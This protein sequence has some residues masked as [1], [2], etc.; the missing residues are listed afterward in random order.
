MSTDK[1]KPALGYEIETG[2]DGR[3]QAISFL[4]LDC[5]I[6]PG[7]K[8]QSGWPDAAEEDAFERFHLTAAESIAASH[9][10]REEFVRPDVVAFAE[11]VAASLKAR[12]QEL[13][14]D[15]IAERI[16][17]TKLDSFA[18]AVLEAAKGSTVKLPWEAEG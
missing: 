2:L 4:M 5:D 12:A 10:Y 3:F 15:N 1:T 11:R 6:G 9:R 8:K 16:A 7:D 18:D 17:S 13:W 14:T